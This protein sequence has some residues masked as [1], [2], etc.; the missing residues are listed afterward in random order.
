M[1]QTER[2]Q[3]LENQLARA[4]GELKAMRQMITK[5]IEQLAVLSQIHVDA[6]IIPQ[7][8]KARMLMALPK[9]EMSKMVDVEADHGLMVFP[10][11][12]K[13]CIY[14]V[15]SATRGLGMLAHVFRW[16]TNSEH[17]QQFFQLQQTLKEATKHES[18]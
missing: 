13:Y 4:H 6:V 17:A 10:M 8:P 5:L 9:K 15:G 1:D 16:I 18:L 2:I 7:E 14:T 12:G 3:E 11:G